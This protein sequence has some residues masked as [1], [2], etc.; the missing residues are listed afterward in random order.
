ME[1]MIF[2]GEELDPVRNY[3]YRLQNKSIFQDLIRENPVLSCLLFV[4]E[5]KSFFIKGISAKTMCKL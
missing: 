4:I 5:H 1:G 2:K 3:F